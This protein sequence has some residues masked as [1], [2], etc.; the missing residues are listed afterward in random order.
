[1]A[2]S[3]L[4]GA[5][6]AMD[7]ATFAWRVKAAVLFHA[8]TLLGGTHDNAWNY[9]VSSLLNPQHV[10]P[11]MLALVCV[12][13][14]V[15]ALIVTS[16]DGVSVDTSGVDDTLLL[17]TVAEKWALVSVKYPNDPLTQQ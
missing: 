3:A 15:A 12:D 16:D 4:L 2:G 14:E 1:M 11:T 17:S 10:D 9:A 5:S 6:R 8:A 13:S 7:D